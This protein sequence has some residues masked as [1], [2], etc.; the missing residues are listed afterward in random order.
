MPRMMTISA[1][2]LDTNWSYLFAGNV[3]SDYSGAD[4]DD[5]QWIPLP[6]ITDWVVTKSAQTGADWFRR[7]VTLTPTEHCVRYIM[8]IEKV[9]ERVDVYVNGY[10][11]GTVEGKRS[12]KFDVTDHVFLGENILAIKLTKTSAKY[13]GFFGRIV[14]QPEPCE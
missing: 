11:V 5:R 3:R 2:S 13:S 14:L 12:A 10:L 4:V 8:H 9:P 7:R 6:G 1:I